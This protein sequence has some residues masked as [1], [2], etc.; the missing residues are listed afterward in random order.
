MKAIWGGEADGGPALT[1]DVH[2]HIDDECVLAFP[3]LL[4]LCLSLFPLLSLLGFSLALL[5]PSLRSR[6]LPALDP[7]LRLQLSHLGQAQIEPQIQRSVHVIL[8]CLCIEL[9]LQLR[10]RLVVFSKVPHL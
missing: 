9:G 7:L 1:V 4:S 8:P 6:F 5:A 3:T 2:I 10:Q